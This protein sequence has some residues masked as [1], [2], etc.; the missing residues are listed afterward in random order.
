M[1]TDAQERYGRFR[2]DFNQRPADPA[3]ASAYDGQ[4]IVAVADVLAD[5]FPVVA[6]LLRAGMLIYEPEPRKR[7]SLALEV[8]VLVSAVMD[9]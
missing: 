9:R 6:Q 1:T 7:Y 3:L 5:E 4:Y 2:R 8:G